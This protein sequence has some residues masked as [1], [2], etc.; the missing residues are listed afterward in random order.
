[1]GFGSITKPL[2]H[3]SGQAPVWALVLCWKILC[4][5]PPLENSFPH[6]RFSPL[7]GGDFLEKRSVFIFILP[8]TLTP[9]TYYCL[10]HQVVALSK[11]N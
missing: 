1:M 6:I 7:L 3:C 4:L 8:T 9:Y 5:I 10:K 2:I 11:T